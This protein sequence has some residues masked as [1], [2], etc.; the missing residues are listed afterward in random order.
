MKKIVKA[1]SRA[2][3]PYPL[4]KVW[5]TV[6]DLEDFSWRSDLSKIEVKDETHF[7][8]YTKKN[9]PT[10]FTITEKKKMEK[11]TFSLKNKNIK[12]N[13][14]GLFQEIPGGTRLLFTEEIEVSS[15]FMK[16]LAPSYLKKQQKT[17]MNDLTKKL[18]NES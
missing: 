16:I 8:E 14:V 1:V 10:H 11:Y 12:G 6:T 18:S 3:V 5:N 15:L 7:I 9:F 4:E 13:W 2:E 17:Y